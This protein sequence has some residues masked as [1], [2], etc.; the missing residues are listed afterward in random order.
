[1]KLHLCPLSALLFECCSKLLNPDLLQLTDWTLKHQTMTTPLGFL[2]TVS[3]CQLLLRRQ[4]NV[5]APSNCVTHNPTIIHL[6][7]RQTVRLSLQLCS[8]MLNSSCLMGF[9]E[10][11]LCVFERCLNNSSIF[12]VLWAHIVM[13]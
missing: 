7:W 5:F 9:W 6:T 2:L 3:S 10:V 12:I 1:M 11:S 8:Y 13:W 4:T